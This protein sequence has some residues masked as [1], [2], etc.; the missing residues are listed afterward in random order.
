MT[1]YKL[2]NVLSDKECR[3][4]TRSIDGLCEPGIHYGYEYASGIVS[5]SEM[6]T[7]SASNT[8]F[9]K[10]GDILVDTSSQMLTLSILKIKK[11]IED[12]YDT[13][14]DLLD[15][16]YVHM[17]PGSFNGMHSDNSD[18][19]GTP[20]TDVSNLDYSAILYLNNSG[21]DYIG[22][23]IY[24]P[25]D[26][27]TIVPV[28]GQAIYFEGNYKNPHMV[29]TVKSGTRKALVLFFSKIT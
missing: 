9:I 25:K 10:S 26:K 29:K 15:C 28:S 6:K 5:K 12:T 16:G 7:V 17:L 27:T 23:E 8:I 2:D 22:G 19:D 13:N 24:F 11:A 18:L 1:I 4:V 3:Y 20:A 21:V 14:V